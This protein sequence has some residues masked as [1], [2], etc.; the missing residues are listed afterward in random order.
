MTR[1]APRLLLLVPVLMLTACG[2]LP[3]GK[4]NGE[5]DATA[6]QRPLIPVTV[7]GVEGDVAANVH[8][9][10][11]LASRPCD[12]GRAYL[13]A[14]ERRAAEEA[15]T[16]LRAYGYYRAEVAVEV[17]TG[18]DCAAATVRVAPGP[19]VT[20]RQVEVEIA[21]AARDDRGF[22]RA[23][24][25]HALHAGAPLSHAD[26]EAAKSLLETL[27][28]ERG[29]LQGRF[30]RSSL[31]VD[32]A[33][34]QADVRIT[35]D[36]GPR[37]SVG[38]VR[39]L[40]EPVVV[41]ETLIRRFIEVEP[42]APYDAGIVSRIYAALS[43]SEYF[44]AVEVRPL[45]SRPE[46]L[47]IPIEITL[48]ARKRHKYS[49]GV[50]A[51]TDEGIRT[52]FNYVN[53]RVNTLG[54]RIKAELRASLIE[55]R[56]SGEYQIPRAHPSDEWLSLQAGVRREDI[57][58]FET[59]ESRVGVSETKRR[60]WGWMETRFVNLNHQSFD[61]ADDSRA[62]TLVIPGL[63]WNKTV[64]DDPLRPRRGYSLDFEVRGSADFLI[65]DVD[66]ARALLSASAVYGLPAGLRL[67]T[68]ADAGASWVAAFGDLPPS[69]RF[70]A[71]GDVSIRGYAFE[72]LGPEND[73]GEVIGGQYLGV[74]SLELEK[75]IGERWGIAAF[76]DAGNAFGGDGH[77]TGIKVGVGAGVRW[78]SPIGPVRVDLAHPL[79]D[80]TVLR[81]HLRI[82]P[83]L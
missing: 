43:G 22:T 48:S 81:L 44:D 26:Y 13:R 27:A 54:H 3:F 5:D 18:E 64:A 41:E 70:F 21:G 12:T 79:D 15:L 53:R 14:L 39:I 67:L 38:E 11:S 6:R 34:G 78:H 68:R 55:Q 17:S 58:T 28:L 25:R 69:E 83:D 16:A 47:S 37:F 33:A 4:G 9:H 23:A 1:R 8:A 10:V 46:Q 36:S 60:P 29:Y 35:Y 82:G 51:S 24:E 50:G 49:A 52:R 63:R 71:G 42:G 72:D 19:R 59:I 57:D 32:P 77:A 56:L 76:A 20:L 31:R 80:D 65:S 66:F 73:D 45:V 30:T 7:V 61:I 2:Y 62:T 40:Q 74:A 75:A